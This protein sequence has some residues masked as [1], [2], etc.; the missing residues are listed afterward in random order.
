MAA[1]SRPPWRC[2]LPP[3]VGPG[4]PSTPAASIAGTSVFQI[5]QMQQYDDSRLQELLRKNW[6]Q[7]RPISENNQA[8]IAEFKAQLTPETLAHGDPTAGRAVWQKTCAKCHLL[9]GEGG[10]IGPDLTGS[11]RGNLDYLLENIIDPSATLAPQYRMTTI[12]LNDGRVL[13]G[14][15]LARTEQTWEVQTPLEKIV[16]RVADIDEAEDSGR[17]L[18]PEGQLDLLPFEQVRDLIRYVMSPRGAA[19]RRRQDQRRLS[20]AASE[21]VA[22]AW[23]ST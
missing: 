22:V 19:A 2:W 16:L 4:R 6:P 9:F 23:R 17:S 1:I 18:M 12:V 14:V 3:V 10:R 11:Q 20:V 13:N 15:V 5:R 8:R 7:L 21:P